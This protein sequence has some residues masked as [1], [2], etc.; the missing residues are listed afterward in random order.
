MFSYKT[1]QNYF[2]WDYSKCEG[3]YKKAAKLILESER[4]PE[5]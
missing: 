1:C 5:K 3:E 2:V 4:F